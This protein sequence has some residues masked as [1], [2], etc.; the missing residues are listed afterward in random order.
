MSKHNLKTLLKMLGLNIGLQLLMNLY[1]PLKT[2]Y[3]CT[4]FHNKIVCKYGTEQIE[5]IVFYF[6][7]LCKLCLRP[8]D[9][10]L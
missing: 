5:L 9:I 3:V 1:F 2:K 7:R 6:N 8:E 10:C 4:A